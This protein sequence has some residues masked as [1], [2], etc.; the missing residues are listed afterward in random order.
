MRSSLEIY[1]LATGAVRVVLQTD[2]L[3][4]APNWH[5]DGWLLVNG[6]GRLWRVPLDR[7]VLLQVATGFADRCNNDHGISPDG[8][9]IM[10]TCHTDRGAEIFEMPVAGGDPV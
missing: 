8:R 5:P 3:I 2:R 9:R 1:E 10:F 6:E 4:E 7:P